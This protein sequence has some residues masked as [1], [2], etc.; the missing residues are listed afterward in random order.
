M[1][2]TGIIPVL[3]VFVTIFNFLFPADCKFSTAIIIIKLNR[4]RWKSIGLM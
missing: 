2:P 4:A 3:N 1:F